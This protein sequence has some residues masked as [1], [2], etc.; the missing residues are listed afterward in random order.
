MDRRRSPSK[1]ELA[2]YVGAPIGGDRQFLHVA[3]FLSL[4]GR[5][6]AGDEV[7]CPSLTWC[8]SANAV[9]LSGSAASF[10]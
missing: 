10:L 8:S 2:E 3:L 4:P 5:N 1:K 7:I 6:Q 9:A